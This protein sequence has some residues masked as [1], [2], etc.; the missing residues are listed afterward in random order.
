MLGARKLRRVVVN[1]ITCL[2]AAPRLATPLALAVLSVAVFGCAE[3]PAEEP[4]PPPPAAV[5]PAPAPEPQPAP[6]P[7]Q[8][9]EPAPAPAPAVMEPAPKPEPKPEPVVNTGTKANYVGYTGIPWS[10]DYGVVGG[11]CDPAA[12]AKALGAQDGPRAIALAVAGPGDAK[13]IDS[14]DERDRAC[15]GHALELAGDNRR[16]RWSNPDTGTTY[17]LTP[18]RGFARSGHPC[19]EFNLRTTHGGRSETG[20]GQACQTGDGTWQIIS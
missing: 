7:V 2:R 17:L 6:L 9:A 13:L 14:M 20:K 5:T 16:V 1:K 10:R 3:L 4:A 12:A 15:M 8:V 11:R 19:R 18:I